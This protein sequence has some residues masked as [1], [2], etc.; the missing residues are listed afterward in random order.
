MVLVIERPEKDRVDIHAPGEPILHVGYELYR[1]LQLK[2][3]NRAAD[4][5][6]QQTRP[7]PN[8]SDYDFDPDGDQW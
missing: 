8:D 4:F 1:D 3:G 2:F 6:V 5:I 7:L